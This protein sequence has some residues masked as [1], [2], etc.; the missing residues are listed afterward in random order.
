MP[1]TLPAA[2]PAAGPGRFARAVT[3]WAH[4]RPVFVILA[5]YFA[6]MT[7][8][9]AVL[10]PSGHFDDTVAFE[11]AQSFQ[12]GYEAKSPPLF[13]WL[14]RALMLLTGPRI[15]TIFALRMACLFAAFA[16]LTLLARRLQPDTLLAAGAGLAMLATFHFHWYFLDKYA[17]TTLALAM[18]PY[19]LLAFLRLGRRADVWSYALFGLVAGVGLLTRY[20]FA[21]LL[22]AMVAAALGSPKWRTVVCDRRIGLSLG[23]AALITAP[24]FAWFLGH[25]SALRGEV[26]FAVGFHGTADP[27]SAAL[28]ALGNLLE[29]TVSIFL[30]PLAVLLAALLWP[31][32]RPVTV[33]DPERAEDLR[34][35]RNTVIAAF[36]I[37]VL[38]ALGGA[39]RIRSRHL[40]FLSLLPLWLIARLDARRLRPFAAP[41]FLAALY[42]C[43]VVAGLGFPIKGWV[44][45]ERCTRCER[46]LPFDAYA[47]AIAA[48]GFSGG[49]IVHSQEM[50]RGA[51]LRAYFPRTRVV[52][53]FQYASPRVPLRKGAARDCVFVWRAH[54]PDRTEAR[55][56]AGGPVPGVGLPLPGDAIFGTAP[57]TIALSGRPTVT[58]RFALVKGGLGTCH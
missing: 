9:L 45:A 22:A 32:L 29:E 31:A 53:D 18:M 55:L 21:I 20:H 2:L 13:V 27:V 33:A 28:E 24:H 37:M 41:G 52:P 17:N 16:G 19:A 44:Y 54:S 5:L 23:L 25:W 10:T 12:W 34:F 51:L 36:A 49:T 48:A 15:E 3:P 46:V 43:L 58:L 30:F 14:A 8:A 42:G 6:A 7:V 57:G 47:R 11:D 56:K 26:S 40:F 35:L 50:S 39:T 4:P 1:A 38:F